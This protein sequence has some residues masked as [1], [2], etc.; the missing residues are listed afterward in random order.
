MKTPNCISNRRFRSFAV[1]LRFLA[2][3]LI[4]LGLIA[5][6]V[7]AGDET[8]AKKGPKKETAVKAENKAEERTVITGSLIP[9]KVKGGRIPATSTLRLCPAWQVCGAIDR[10]VPGPT[11]GRYMTTT[12]PL[13]QGATL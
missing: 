7:L 13:A 5:G 12:V 3:V 2:S 6:S 10:Q 11:A 8:G 9:Q 4:G 1:S